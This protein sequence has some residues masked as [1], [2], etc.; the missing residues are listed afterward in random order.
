M[1]AFG[2][3]SLAVVS[4]I[5]VQQNDRQEGQKGPITKEEILNIMKSE[6]DDSSL[7]E[8]QTALRKQQPG[9]NSI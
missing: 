1:L 8:S 9:R 7:S 3:I 4:D 5:V 2:I 6:R